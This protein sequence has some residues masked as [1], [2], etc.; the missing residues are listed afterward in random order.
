MDPKKKVYAR[1][2]IEHPCT[3]VV[4]TLNIHTL[5]LVHDGT[6]KLPI[7]LEVPKPLY[8]VGPGE[9]LTLTLKIENQLDDATAHYG[10]SR[11]LHRAGDSLVLQQRFNNI[12]RYNFGAPNLNYTKYIQNSGSFSNLTVYIKF[13]PWLR[14]DAGV[15]SVSQQTAYWLP[16]GPYRYHTMALLQIF[17]DLRSRRKIPPAFVVYNELAWIFNRTQTFD[18]DGTSIIPL[19]KWALWRPSVTCFAHSQRAPRLR[20]YKKNGSKR[21]PL[22]KSSLVFG[23]KTVTGEAFSVKQGSKNNYTCNS[24]GDNQASVDFQIRWYEPVKMVRRSPEART[25]SVRRQRVSRQWIVA[26]TSVQKNMNLIQ[27]P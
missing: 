1:I 3:T 26:Y 27:K 24:I 23:L 17:V 22:G 6:I 7:L 20:A 5:Q 8:I 25:I 13:R 12:T 4:L 19:P 10:F 14:T 2:S 9:E 21:I 15:Y 16:G 11:H 18:Q